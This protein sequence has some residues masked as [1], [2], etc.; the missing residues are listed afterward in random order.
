[1]R[2][3]AVT[4]LAVFYGLFI[5]SATA[6]RANDW[7]AKVSLFRHSAPGH[8]VPSFEKSDLHLRQTKIFEQGFVVES[9]REG[10]SLP[11]HSDRHSPLPSTEYHATWIGQA[12]SS[13]APPVQI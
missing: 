7:A 10:I 1:M 8:A 13:R 3:F 4:T 2:K 5:I 12:L 9:P 11:T 6:E